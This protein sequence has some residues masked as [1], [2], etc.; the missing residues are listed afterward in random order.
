MKTRIVQVSLTATVV[1]L[2]AVGAIYAQSPSKL[3]ADIPFDFHVGDATLPAGSYIV[4]PTGLPIP[5]LKI[6]N[7]SN[8]KGAFAVTLPGSTANPSVQAKLVFNRRP[9]P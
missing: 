4:Q 2:L 3:V 6:Q 7:R 8:G 5:V 1:V 9:A